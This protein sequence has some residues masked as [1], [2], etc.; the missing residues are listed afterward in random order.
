MSKFKITLKLLSFLWLRKGYV[1]LMLYFLSLLIWAILY[2]AFNQYLIGFLALSYSNW[3]LF[4]FFNMDKP[5][6]KKNFF[7]IYNISS[8][9]VLA[10]KILLLYILFL[11]QLPIYIYAYN[12]DGTV[13]VFFSIFMVYTIFHVERSIPHSIM[14]ILIYALMNFL[15]VSVLIIVSFILKGNAYIIP[16]VILM[17]IIL[18]ELKSLKDEKYSRI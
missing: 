7:R 13:V 10:S 17:I 1:Y 6:T 5:L 8:D 11:L 3:L 12:L 16:L 4:A 9:L 14:K 15:Y 2:F 18:I